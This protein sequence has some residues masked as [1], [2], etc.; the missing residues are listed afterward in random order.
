M[1]LFA[2]YLQALLLVSA[3]AVAMAQYGHGGY[4]GEAYGAHDYVSK[5]QN[6]PMLSSLQDNERV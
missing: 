4:G 3:A 6:F 1:I 2:F 5:I